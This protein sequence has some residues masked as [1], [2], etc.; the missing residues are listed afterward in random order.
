MNELYF[1][2]QQLKKLI[3][4]LAIEQFLTMLVGFMDTVM[5]SQVG[6]TA[7]SAVSLVDTINVLLIFVFQ[8]LATGGAVVASQYFG[9]GSKENAQHSAKQLVL[10]TFGISIIIMIICLIF[11][12]GI[13]A[14]VFGD[15]ETAVMDDCL[16]YF[17]YSLLSY[18]F[19]A[20]F[21]SGAA[22][23]RTMGKASISM[24]NSL[25]M[26]VMNIILNAFFIFV[27]NMGVAG[28]AIATLISRITGC[29]IVLI[30]LK[31]KNHDIYIDR[32]LSIRPD[33]S[34]IKKIMTI[35]IPTGL[36]N[37]IFQLGKIMV[38]SLVATLGTYAIAANAV[39]S[40]MAQMMIIPGQAVGLAMVNVVGVCIGANDYQQVDYYIK[41]MMKIAY[42]AMFVTSFGVALA[43]PIIFKLYALSNETKSLAYICIWMHAIF[44]AIIWP[45]GFAFPNA[46]RAANDARY[47]MSVSVTSMF[48]CR[49]SLSFIFVKYLGFG[50]VGVWGAMIID[51]FVRAGF[52]VYRYKSG[53]WKNKQ[54]V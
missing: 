20:L 7:V 23:F 30:L 54:L 21:N 42:I 29:V 2:N 12:K 18:P 33:F 9:Q 53:K 47:T 3:I 51:W 49:Y 50:L 1:S 4:P 25:I 34:N 14:L 40:N 24:V 13:L 32:Y 31:N 46:L 22:L 48:L 27:L 36:E 44:G 52:F 8:A 17:F 6:E 35:G 5:V 43:S 37:G 38:Q 39:T 15:V 28:V 19:I 11:K 45:L 16:I 10:V 26:N 41:K